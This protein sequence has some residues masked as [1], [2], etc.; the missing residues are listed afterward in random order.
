MYYSLRY[1]FILPVFQLGRDFVGIVTSKGMKVADE[2]LRIGDKVWGVV[3]VWDKGCHSEY[4]AIDRKFVANKPES[5]SDIEASSLLYAGLT[6]W[7]GG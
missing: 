7:S 2:D 6:C 4:L 3:P 1:V 5:L